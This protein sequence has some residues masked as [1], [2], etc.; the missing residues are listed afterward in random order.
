MRG[1][2][3]QIAQATKA[4][5]GCCNDERHEPAGN[6]IGE[7]LDRGAAALRLRHHLDDLRQHGVAADFVGAHDESAAFVH[8][9]ADDPVADRLADGH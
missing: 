7:A 8:R 2:G 4:S 3:P 6:L 5:D 1:S 9:S